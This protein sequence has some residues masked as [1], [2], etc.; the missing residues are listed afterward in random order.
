MQQ[1]ND[2]SQPIDF[3]LRSFNALDPRVAEDPTQILYN[4]LDSRR[5]PLTPDQVISSTSS[6]GFHHQFSQEESS[7][8]SYT[9]TALSLGIEGSYGVYSGS[10]AVDY[11]KET[12]TTSK[13]TYSNYTSDLTSGT[14]LFSQSD[15]P[16]AIAA[17]INT[18]AVDALNA[19]RTL[20]DA[21]AFTKTHGTHVVLGVILGGTLSIVIQSS[22]STFAQK[23]TLSS[24]IK[25]NYDGIGSMS[26]VAKAA[27][28]SK[29]AAGSSSLKQELKALGGTVSALAGLD[30]ADEASI[31]A[32]L[33]TCDASSVRA[34]YKSTEWWRLASNATASAVLKHYLDLCLLKHSLENPVVFSSY[35]PLTAYQYN[36]VTATVDAGY[37]IIGGGAWL[38][39]SGPDFLTACFPTLDSAQAVNG[40]QTVSHDCMIPSPGGAALVA[41]ALGVHDPANL[42]KIVCTSAQGSNPTIGADSATAQVAD[43]CLLTGGGIETGSGQ[44][45][46]RF[47][48]GSF[49]SA[50]G[51]SDYNAWVAR[52][53]D[54]AN[55]S[56]ATLQAW[57][58]G[59]K[60]PGAPEIAISKIVVKNNGGLQSHGTS[61]AGLGT[62]QKVAGGGTELEQAGS[63][64]PDSLQNLLHASF[65]TN[66]Q[67]VFGWQ[68]FDGDLNGVVDK[69]VATAYAFTLRVSSTV[70]GVTFQPYAVQLMK[71]VLAEA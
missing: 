63:Q 70:A 58:V 11:E 49:P 68:E 1:A 40:W 25:A 15:D 17:N 5:S 6:N 44:Q 56:A 8:S 46:A 57:A 42:L 26:A 2:S 34:L 9:K 51:G 29:V 18:A 32:W 39:P 10:V 66:Q 7:Q 33:A 24:E 41:Y 53:H 14:L 20:A 50:V 64:S 61:F 21:E 37:K 16:T 62:G 47:V 54:Y 4:L 28:D 67:G 45:Y 30:L 27:H 69:V 19:I 60:A 3:L 71:K 35:G 52:G 55:A 38:D 48:T 59:I 31:K 23:E 22:A 13:T 65:P 43:G 12:D 36:T